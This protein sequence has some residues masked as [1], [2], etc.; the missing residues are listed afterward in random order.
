MPAE[1]P[2]KIKIPVKNNTNEM[3]SNTS[4]FDQAI[5]AIG[6]QPSYTMKDLMALKTELDELLTAIKNNRSMLTQKL[7]NLEV[8]QQAKLD[9]Q[10]R[11]Q[12]AQKQHV[13]IGEEDEDVKME[14]ASQM[15]LEQLQT[16]LT[17]KRTDSL[18][19][20]P[21]SPY[22]SQKQQVSTQNVESNNL[23]Q[24]DI[25]PPA[26]P[27]DETTTG[28]LDFLQTPTNVLASPAA[29][30]KSAAS[31][32]KKKRKRQV[33]DDDDD[34]EYDPNVEQAAQEEEEELEDELDAEEDGGDQSQ[35][36]KKSKAAKAVL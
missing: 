8:T 21:S 30:K 24:T 35:Q 33:V 31:T 26:T 15:V 23:L 14:D 29:K 5:K 6:S 19:A 2:L 3:D 18:L 25:V 17:A 34:E 28:A 12:Q 7:E 1:E 36:A 9:A 13:Q 11:Q 22:K 10:H 16:P 32:N 20:T 4:L 27:M